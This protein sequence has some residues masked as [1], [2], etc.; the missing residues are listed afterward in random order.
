MKRSLLSQEQIIT[1]IQT[2]ARKLGHPPSRAELTRMTGI[3]WHPIW[4]EFRGMRGALRAAGLEPGPKGEPPEKAALLLDWAGVV[5]RVQQLPSRR[6][7]AECGRY[8]SGTLHRRV[9]WCPGPP[10]FFP[11][12]PAAGGPRGRAGRLGKPPPN[13]FE[14]PSPPVDT[15]PRVSSR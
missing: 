8:S 5:R 13:S 4:T 15:P 11:L 10:P 3:A 9:K 1:A 7:Y 14:L 6:Q 12:S 2:C